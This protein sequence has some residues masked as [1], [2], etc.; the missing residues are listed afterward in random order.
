MRW[1]T[2]VLVSFLL[3]VFA[4][5]LLLSVRQNS[6]TFDENNHL[7]AGY[8]Y[9]KR[10]D[11]GI[12]PEHPPLVKLVAALPLLP[13][14]LPVQPPP[15]IYFR[16]AGGKGGVQF[17]YSH[18]ADALLF[19]ARAGASAF[20]LAL[21]LLVFFAARE[22]FGRLAAIFALVIFILEPVILGHGP[23]VTTD[24]GLAACMFA[25][26]YS[27]YRYVR[28]PSVSGL[29]LCGI[30]TGLT[31][32]AKHS[33]LIVFPI[34]LLL[35]LTD[36]VLRR[37]GSEGPAADQEAS[38]L[39][40]DALTMAG[41]LAGIAAISIAVLWSFYGFRYAAR[42]AAAQITPPTAVFLHSLETNA[43]QGRGFPAAYHPAQAKTIGFFEKHHLLPEAYLYGLTDIAV[44]TQQGRPIFLFGKLYPQGRW[45]YFPAAFAI[46]SSIALLALLLFLIWAKDIRRVQF[47]REVI[48]LALPPVA[49][50]AVAMNSKMQMGIRHIM[51]VYPFLI[52]LAGVAAWSVSQRSRR[53]AY[54]MAVLLAFDAV[55]SLRTFPNYL[56]YSNEFWG[57]GSKTHELLSDSNVGWMSGLRTMQQYVSEHHISHCWF[58]YDGPQDP[59][60][61]HI[62]C[63][64]L[65]TL[66]A[67]IARPHQ[68]QPI[69]EHIDGP[70]FFSSEALDGFDFGPEG[71]NPYQQFTKRKPDALL[72]GEILVFNGR[73]DVTKPAALSHYIAARSLSMSGNSD[74]AILEG[75]AASALDPN[76]RSAH[77]LLASLYF[78]NKQM[79]EARSE[80]QSALH[81]YDTIE[82]EFQRTVLGPPGN[83]FS[84]N[85]NAAVAPTGQLM[86]ANTSVVES[87]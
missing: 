84:M 31:L 55:A 1:T 11:F 18:D 49:Y 80:Y 6:Q 65:P 57:G 62:P 77:E 36:I 9:W 30:T 38:A 46:K 66:F 37:V 32:A 4:A 51:P 72:T 50:F 56:P 24:V 10:G 53:W 61:Y 41:A 13:L 45:F 7:Y 29:I 27:F 16:A 25:A 60:Y 42:P 35:A 40:H 28:H 70:L 3:C 15:D 17:L 54:A 39:R 74:R 12:N 64:P 43:A 14:G 20:A 73:F 23:L 75:K 81:V 82:P 26:V 76:L 33:G 44:L 34:L 59:A 79:D 52:V 8:S 58:A 71:M 47:R 2:A 68:V 86:K 67:M 78:K 69:P 83:P 5:E 85:M 21:A 22:M 48:F 87:H 19:R 63:A